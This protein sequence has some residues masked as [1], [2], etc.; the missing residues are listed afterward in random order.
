MGSVAHSRITICAG[1]PVHTPTKLC[2][3]LPID[4]GTL[5]TTADW[6]VLV[7]YWY[8]SSCYR[9]K[10]SQEIISEGRPRI[11][12]I[13]V[14]SLEVIHL[15]EI[16][17]NVCVNCQTTFCSAINP[18][19]REIV[20]LRGLK[21]I[22]LFRLKARPSITRVLLGWVDKI[23]H[24]TD[25][26]NILINCQTVSRDLTCSTIVPAL[27]LIGD[28]QRTVSAA[29]LRWEVGEGMI[30]TAHHSCGGTQDCSWPGDQLDCCWI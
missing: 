15:S 9:D 3:A 7:M 18:Q 27:P 19:I 20:F 28:V 22:Y 5:S 29:T 10:T 2:F 6:T 13:S 11:T 1:N 14:G 23:P 17:K 25:L 21:S 26:W 4:C 8:G 24:R 12:S 16:P 30:S